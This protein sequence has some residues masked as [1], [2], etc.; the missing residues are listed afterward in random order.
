MSTG[1]ATGRCW[2]SGR[3]PGGAFV[4]TVDKNDAYFSVASDVA[5]VIAPVRA[6][7]AAPERDALPRVTGLAVRRGLTMTAQTTFAGE[8]QSR[9]PRKWCADLRDGHFSWAKD[10]DVL[11]PLCERLEALPGQERPRPSPVYRLARFTR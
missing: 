2:C 9:S 11:T 3:W 6:A 10:A 7:H 1:R 5:R 4:T 8:G